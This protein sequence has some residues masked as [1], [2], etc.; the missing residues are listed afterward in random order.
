MSNRNIA[1]D[2]F[3]L[4]L[5]QKREIAD[6]LGMKRLYKMEP[7]FDF[8]SRVLVQAKDTGRLAELGEKVAAFRAAEKS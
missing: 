8:Y 3:E 1:I 7:D 6:W 5:S 2:F 4:R